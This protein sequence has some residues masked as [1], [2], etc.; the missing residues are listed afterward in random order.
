M[1]ASSKSV[2][3]S[4]AREDF[5]SAQK[6][7]KVLEDAGL[8]PWLDKE[9]ILPG[10]RWKF[11][12]HQAI[13]NSRFFIPLFSSKSVDKIGYIQNELKYAMKA[14]KKFPEKEVYIIPARL[15]D[16]KIP[17]EIEEEI[18]LVNLFPDW[19]KGVKEIFKTFKERGIEIQKE[20]DKQ[21]PSYVKEEMKWQTGLSEDDWH[22]LLASVCN[23]T[24]I[25]FIG[26]GTLTIKSGDGKSLISL[27]KKIIEEYERYRSEES[28]AL[29]DL[30]NLSKVHVLEDPNRLAKLA[31]FSEIM[32][33][34]DGKLKLPKNMLK[35]I[36][37]NIDGFMDKSPYEILASLDLSIYMTTNYDKFMELALK[38]PTKTPQ[39]EFCR[40]NDDIIKYAKDFGYPSI[41]SK[42]EY[43]PT[44]GKPLIYHILG[45]IDIPISM[46]LTEKE[47]LEFMIELN[48][49]EDLIPTTIRKKL[50]RSSLLFIG[51][52][53]EDINFRAIF[54]GFLNF[55]SSLS[56]E[57]RERE[58]SVAVQIPPAISSQDQIRMQKYLDHY[59]KNLFQIRV[60]WDKTP[61][62]LFELSKRWEDFKKKN[63][64][65]TCLPL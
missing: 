21:N 56:P 49:N 18:Q 20:P 48:K 17:D 13:K 30:Y 35:D 6:L 5:E 15:D 51:Y 62:F 27:S 12:I 22:T 3:I 31:Q 50:P 7:Y 43:E 11:A 32:K 61:E 14:A 19:N 9:A 55:L 65:K 24:C 1:D 59:T 46:V 28:P 34:Y 45:D 4:Y 40:W 53:L 39:S 10:H 58:I 16:C 36:L 63:D 23:K 38:G 41:F 8:K 29:E 54:Q 42:R 64:M 2:F 33:S 37:Q 26:S 25:P 57:E 47:Y 44:P 52:S 60:Y